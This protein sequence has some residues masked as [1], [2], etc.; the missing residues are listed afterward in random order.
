MPLAPGDSARPKR[1]TPLADH[2]P[3]FCPGAAQSVRA[4]PPLASITLRLPSAKNAIDWLSGDQDSAPDIAAPPGRMPLVLARGCAT[5]LS[6]GRVHNWAVWDGDRPTNAIVWPLGDSAAYSNP[7][8][9]G[10]L[11]TKRRG[12]RGSGR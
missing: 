4:G 3:L 5:M 8:S 7:A 10:G 11:T 6:I 9:V 1:I 2:D 12:A